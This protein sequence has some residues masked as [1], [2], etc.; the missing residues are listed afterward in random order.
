PLQEEF[1]R[2]QSWKDR[3]LRIFS[4]S[5]YLLT[6]FLKETYPKQELD[7]SF[8]EKHFEDTFRDRRKFVDGLEKLSFEEQEKLPIQQIV[9]DLLAQWEGLLMAKAYNTGL[10]QEFQDPS[11]LGI[12][13]DWQR[14][15]M[16]PAG[17]TSHQLS[18]SGGKEKMQY[19]ISGSYMNQQGIIEGSGFDRF[20]ARLNLDNQVKDWF[21]VGTTFTTSRT[22]ERVTLN[23]D[24]EGVVTNALL[25]SPDVPVRN[26][27]G[28]YGGPVIENGA[29]VNVNPVAKS[30]LNDNTITRVR[31]L[32]N[33]YAD[34]R[35]AKN[36]NF[37]SEFGTDMNFG[38]NDQFR[39][40]YEWGRATNPTAS[41]LKSNNNSQFWILKN[42]LTYKLN[43]GK[44]NLTTMA[45]HE[46]QE[47]R[48]NGTTA[49]RVNFITN[50]VKEL[51]VGD[52]NGQTGDSYAGDAALESYYGRM[53]YS[54]DG[55]YTVTGTLRS[56]GSS[57]FA[58]GQ[59]W[60]LFPSL[61]VAWTLSMSRL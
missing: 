53:I 59:K 30:L 8:Y 19:Y 56:D 48:W 44:H 41:A 37:R 42:Y 60:G 43:V 11:L 26:I 10:R 38:K 2:L 22:F 45:G 5:W 39:P 54:F 14:E 17:M 55:K 32:G 4:E 20:T 33:F 6:N 24:A 29:V 15:L 28:S 25:Q 13:T 40:T 3:P 12:G 57:K 23:D 52:K 36:L 61:A 35:L 1:R 47:S 21:H 49:T 7:V 16:K 34:V 9:Y 58:E 50:D 46:V 27:D 18:I 31:V 51:S